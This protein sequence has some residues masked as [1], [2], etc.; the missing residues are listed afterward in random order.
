MKKKKFSDHNVMWKMVHV[1]VD[2]GYLVQ[3]EVRSADFLLP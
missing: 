2:Q 1:F 3:E